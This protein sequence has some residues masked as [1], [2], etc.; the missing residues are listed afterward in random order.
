MN[1]KHIIFLLILL[2]S[3]ESLHAQTPAEW[4]QM[5]GDITFY[6]VNDNGRNGYYDQ[7]AIAETMGV[8]G[9]TLK[10]E[11]VVAVGD[12]HHFNGI[13]SVTDPLWTTN[14]ELVYSH[15]E[16][17][18]DWYPVLGNHE[19]RGNTQACLDYSRVSRRWVMPARYYTKVL[20]D[21]SV[22]VRI[23]MLD[24]SPMIDKYRNDS[25]TYPDAAQQD[26][27]PQLAWLDSVLTN[28]KEDWV[29]CFGH[30]PIYADTPKNQSER[31]DMQQ[32][33]LPVLRKHNNVA[34]YACGH[35]HNFQHIKKEDDPIDYV[36]NSSAS[37]ARKVKPIE[38]TV[39]CS[40]ESGFSVLAASK[41]TLKMYF[42][43]KNGK[44]IHLVTKQK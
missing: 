33:L 36:V 16:L 32:R 12:V 18:L 43:D 3:L 1:K 42:I 14:Y 30:H 39:F 27:K 31:N 25:A 2:F 41:N 22:T 10:P 7:K 40:Q 35:I 23:V 6:M 26:Y 21:N 29:I 8:M 13:A 4:K 9:E 24:T 11:C 5:K 38:G 17:M 15:P 20:K 28:A 37:L 34:V 19:Y 44:M